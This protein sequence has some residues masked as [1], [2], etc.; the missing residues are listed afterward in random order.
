MNDWFFL[1]MTRDCVRF[2]LNR[3]RFTSFEK[4]GSCSVQLLPLCRNKGIMVKD[5]LK[6]RG[7]G[8]E[9]IGQLS[10]ELRLAVPLA[11]SL[12]VFLRNHPEEA[13]RVEV[14]QSVHVCM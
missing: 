12:E 1:Y 2:E 3:S 14:I 9:V 10:V 4:L 13:K 11:Q 8:G 6:I 5:D 7:N